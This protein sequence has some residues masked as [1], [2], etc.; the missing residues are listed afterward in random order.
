M[1]PIEHTFTAPPVQPTEHALIMLSVTPDISHITNITTS[2]SY[3]THNGTIGIHMAHIALLVKLTKHAFIAPTQSNQTKDLIWPLIS[4][5]TTGEAHG[6]QWCTDMQDQPAL[7]GNHFISKNRKGNIL[8][9]HC[10]MGI[11]L[12]WF[13]LHYL[14]D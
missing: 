6:R 13:E 14:F 7:F 5:R 8:F 9:E 11:S 4:T 2:G 12:L 1:E 3:G 10:T